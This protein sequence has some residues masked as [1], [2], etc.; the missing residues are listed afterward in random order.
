[1]NNAF[2]PNAA[3]PPIRPLIRSSGHQSAFKII[4]AVFA[5]MIAALLG[6]IV[7]ALIGSETGP[8]ELVI[9]LICATLP[10]PIYVMLLL[11]IDRYESEPLWM[12]ATAFFWGAV[13][14]VFIAFI[15]NTS[16][17][18]MAAVAT[19]NQQIGE[20]V[21]AVIS[22]P[23]VEESAKALILLILFFWKRD[24]F[25][26][27]IDGIVYAGM[28]G[29]GFAMT[30]NIL[31]YGRAVQ[32]GPDALTFIFVLRGMAAP[33]SHPLFTSMTGIG[34]GWSRQS[35][36][37]FIKLVAPVLGFMLAVLMHATWNGSATY[38]GGAG[39]FAAYFGIMGPAF[40]ITLMVI[41]FS[42]RREGRIVRQFLY[43]DFQNGF[44]DPQEYERLCS[45]RGRMGLSWTVL[46]KQGFSPWRTRMQCNQLASE[47]AFHRSRVARGIG[48]N[49]NLAEE[50][51]NE[52]LFRLQELRQKLGYGQKGP[53]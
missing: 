10:V 26:G 20:N 24:E 6:L 39:F 27:I 45:I 32:H 36:H 14:A 40:I 51:E 42:L 37:P 7:L 38:G 35:N 25:D 41:F 33:F 28:V 34:L 11:W 8:T 9:G 4:L 19:H 3:S 47:L 12:L 49:P 46:T 21:G 15:F 43:P 31:Y 50:R 2:T 44:F 23:I 17:S 5:V 18:I 22:A 13:V 30:E 16:I 53:R 29:L 1:M 52:Y 48:R